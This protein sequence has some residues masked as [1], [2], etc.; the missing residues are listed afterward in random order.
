MIMKTSILFIYMLLAF[1]TKAAVTVSGKIVENTSNEPLEY[2]NIVLLSLPDS[3]FLTGTTSNEK[4]LFRFDNLNSG[5][6]LLKISYV[7]FE[8]RHVRADV[9]SIPVDLGDIRLDESN[10]LNEVVVTSKIP[11]FQSGIN[12]GIVANVSTTLLST[13]GTA[14]DVLQRM[15]GVVSENGRITVFGKGAPIVYINNRKIQDASELERLESSEISTVELITSP[16]AKYDAEGRAVLLIKTKNRTSG[17]SAQITERFRVGKYLGDNENVSAAYAQG[18]LNLFASYYHN[19]TKRESTEDH[20][21]TLKNA[22]GLW[23]HTTLLP[24]YLYY[25]NSQ[26]ATAGFDYSLNDKHVIGGQYQFY[27][28]GYEYDMP[29]S[30]STDLDDALFETSQSQSY[31]KDEGCQHLVN[32]FYN[33]DFSDRFSL[34]LDFD[35]LKNHNNKDQQTEESVNSAPANAVDIFNQT[36]YDLYAGKLTNGWKSDSG[37]IEFGGEYNNIA[38]NGFVRSN[39]ATDNTEFTNTEKKAAAFA[40][41]SHKLAG[42]NVVAGLRYEYTTEHYT[43]GSGRKPIIDRTYSDWYPNFSVSGA[44]KNV[45]LSL[46]FNKRTQ[47]PNFNQLNGNVIY[48]NRF[49]FQKGDPYLNKSNI[50]DLNLQAT[51]KAFY[52]NMGYTYIKNPVLLFFTEQENNPNAILSTYANFP[53]YQTLHAT[54]NWNTKIAFWQPNYSIDLTKPFF[55]ANYDGQM[56]EYD[57]FNYS[58]RAYND[59]MLPKG[60]VLSCNFFHWSDRQDAFFE[61]KGY[62]RFDAG[63]R[64]S[65]LNNSLRFNLMVY[66]L[67]DGVKEKAHMQLDNIFWDTDKK[68]ETRYVTLSITY[69]FNNY[70]KKYRGESAAQDDINRF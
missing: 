68:N 16:G 46:A 38:G 28:S 50:Y 51:F 24:G 31:T 40:S 18:G 33:G 1:T 4:G 8:D 19:Y 32:A 14:S 26:Q 30:T 44:M 49:V 36:D 17:F 57:K 56:I 9:S 47:R 3:T 39:G 58:L 35:Y 67:F 7:G 27:T 53:E 20:F 37:I 45:D 48:V 43:E 70:K 41:Y 11:P 63:L 13:V 10:V 21:F 62:Q 29:I 54:L 12:G 55:S 69:M 61:S 15:P 65:F 64:K 22:D 23:K 25:G 2:A 60:W 66:D 59:F 6:Y 5:K 42:M 34:R 52:L